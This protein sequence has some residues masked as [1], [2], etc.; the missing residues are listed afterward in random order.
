MQKW[1]KRYL[2]RLVSFVFEIIALFKHSWQI[3]IDKQVTCFLNKID[4]MQMFCY[5]YNNEADMN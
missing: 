5:S 4:A 3:S 2:L 1:N